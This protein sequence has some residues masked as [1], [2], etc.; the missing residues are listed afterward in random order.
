MKSSKNRSRCVVRSPCVALVRAITAASILAFSTLAWAQPAC[1]DGIDNDGD[2][3]TDW[4]YDLGCHGPN[5][6]DEGAQSRAQENGWTTYDPA[7]DTVVIYVSS[8]TGDDTNDGQSP[9]APV[10]SVARGL[11]LIRDGSADWL[12]FRRGDTWSNG[13]NWG[14]RSGRS[15]DERIVVASYGTSSERPRFA[16]GSAQGISICCGPQSNVSFLDLDFHA[17]TRDPDSPD[18]QGPQGSW[19]IRRCCGGGGNLL[20]EGSRFRHYVTSVLQ[21]GS[22]GAPVN[23]EFRRNVVAGNYSVDSHSQGIF[24]SHV[25][26]LLIEENVFDHNGWNE[27]IDG[28]GATIFNHNLYLSGSNN[29]TVRENL[30]LRAS[31]MG[32][33][34]RSDIMN[35]MVG[36]SVVDNLFVE[37]EIGISIGGNTNQAER[38]RDVEIKDN[39]LT[40][41]GRSNPTGRDFAWYIDVIDNRDVLIEDNHLLHQPLWTNA[42]G[43]QLRGGS[44]INVSVLENNFYGIRGRS[45]QVDG[46][47]GWSSVRIEDNRLEDVN[48]SHLIEESGDRTALSYSGNDYCAAAPSG[49]WFQTDAGAMSLSE[50]QVYA[51]EPDALLHCHAYTDPTRTVADYQ[52]SV[53]GAPSFADFVQVARQQSKW[54]WNAAYTAAVVNDYLRRGFDVGSEVFFDRFE[55]P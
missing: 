38:F 44:M 33:K 22:D 31:S 16:T 24:A 10:A 53:G 29:V 39:V 2:G 20:F 35:D 4:H 19:A 37:G 52:A 5:D 23:I 40:H 18:F 54:Q 9:D 43:V 3:L 32:I 50:W 13:F 1:S 7:P 45:I 8:A 49:A 42:F 17:Q 25:N 28:G 21:T 36:V 30:F 6:P 41:I 47:A 15:D 11:E 46:S 34:F 48:G 27:T 26:G 12:L 51:S 55:Q 14:E